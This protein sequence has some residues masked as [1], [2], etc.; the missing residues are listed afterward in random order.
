MSDFSIGIL[1]GILAVLWL[2]SLF[3][4]VFLTGKGNKWGLIIPLLSILVPVSVLI[5]TL[6]NDAFNQKNILIIVLSLIPTLSYFFV[7]RVCVHK[8]RQIT[9]K[10]EK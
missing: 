10:Q 7:Y 9:G 5:N 2:L 3:L 4:E 1:M 8:K 6:Q